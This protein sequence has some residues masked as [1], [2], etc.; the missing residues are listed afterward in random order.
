IQKARAA[1]QRTVCQSQLRQIGVA[2][3]TAQDS[4]QSMPGFNQPYFFPGGMLFNNIS[5]AD[6]KSFN[7]SV[8]FWLLPWI[9][10]ANL[11]QLWD[12]AG[13]TAASNTN[14]S[15]MNNV[16]PLAY[17]VGQD[18][19]MPPSQFIPLTPKIYL[20]PSDPSSNFSLTTGLGNNNQQV[21]SYVP[22]R[23]LFSHPP[24]PPTPPST[25]AGAPSPAIFSEKS[26]V[27]DGTNMDSRDMGKTP[28]ATPA[29]PPVG[30][31]N[32]RRES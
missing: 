9:D 12:V 2:L 15:G 29:P 28:P 24:A 31:Y 8:H 22:T 30:G 17:A 7:G 18:I 14:N 23:Q 16:P 26:A 21:T 32:N 1:A 20:C 4:Y 13:A 10:N 5:S 6:Q 11:M 19:A 3:H 27:C 25:P